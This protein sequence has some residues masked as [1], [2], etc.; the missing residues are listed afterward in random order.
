MTTVTVCI[1]G[2]WFHLSCLNIKTTPHV[3]SATVL[4]A[5]VRNSSLLDIKHAKQTFYTM[6]IYVL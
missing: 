2:Q 3:K 1:S 4:P 5:E 6:C